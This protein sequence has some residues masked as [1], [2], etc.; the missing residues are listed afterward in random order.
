MRKTHL[1]WLVCVH[2]RLNVIEFQ[3]AGDSAVGLV[4][5]EDGVYQNMGVRVNQSLNLNVSLVFRVELIE[6]QRI[7]GSVDEFQDALRI[8]DTA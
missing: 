3:V 7:C 2:L 6:H 5:R 4:P 8:P 1:T